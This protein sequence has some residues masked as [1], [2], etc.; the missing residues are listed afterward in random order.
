MGGRA[1]AGRIAPPRT[2][3]VAARTRSVLS[4]HE[5]GCV[6]GGGHGAAP[7][8]AAGRCAARAWPRALTPQPPPPPGPTVPVP[9]LV[10]HN[11]SV[12]HLKMAGVKFVAPV[13]LPDKVPAI[14]TPVSEIVPPLATS[15]TVP[16]PPSVT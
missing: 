6:V 8:R 1:R 15:R 9:T 16:A 14:S 10:G 5:N 13:E 2:P 4:G 12:P 3:F 7:N 11:V